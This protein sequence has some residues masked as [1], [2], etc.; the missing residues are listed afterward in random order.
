VSEAAPLAAPRASAANAK[1]TDIGDAFGRIRGTPIG[2]CADPKAAIHGWMI[3]QRPA[4]V[5]ELQ[6]L[7]GLLDAELHVRAAAIQ[8]VVVL[9]PARQLRSGTRITQVQPLAEF[10][11]QLSVSRPVV[12]EVEIAADDDGAVG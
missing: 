6:S 9:A 4:P 5:H 8:D 11:H 12:D 3:A 1:S 7:A 2:D 10:R